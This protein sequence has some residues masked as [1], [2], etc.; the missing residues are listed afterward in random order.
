MLA[1]SQINS[2]S[3][4]S[5]F[6]WNLGHLELVILY[7]PISPNCCFINRRLKTPAPRRPSGAG[8]TEAGDPCFSQMSV[9][10]FSGF[11]RSVYSVPGTAPVAGET[12]RDTT[13]SLQDT[14][15]GVKH[16]TAQGVNASVPRH[17]CDS[18]VSSGCQPPHLFHS[19]V[20]P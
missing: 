5:P 10:A 16:Q 15:H 4:A 1:N 3:F 7:A 2:G 20:P 13:D 14:S 6:S 19:P 11:L 18:T 12:K 8:R 17:P 9:T